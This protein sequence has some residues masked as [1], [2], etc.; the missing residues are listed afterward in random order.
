MEQEDKQLVDPVSVHAH[1][2][3]FISSVFTLGVLALVL[4]RIL[5]LFPV[6]SD[7]YFLQSV[8]QEEIGSVVFRITVQSVWVGRNVG[9]HNYRE[10]HDYSVHY[11]C[12]GLELGC[13]EE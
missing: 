11:A 3:E 8:G 13:V 6:G 7:N 10:L 5:S 1:R 2:G 12:W 4:P 9:D